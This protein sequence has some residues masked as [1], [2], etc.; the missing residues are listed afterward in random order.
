MG[1]YE[2]PLVAVV[3]MK[4]S[5]ITS[6]SVGRAAFPCTAGKLIVVIARHVLSKCFR[7]FHD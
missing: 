1:T 3:I 6:S 2:L 7:T 4:Q 5:E